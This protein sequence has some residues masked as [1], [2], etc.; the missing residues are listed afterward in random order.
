MDTTSL[1]VFRTVAQEG[2][3]SKAALSLN[4]VQ[5]NVTAKIKQL[6]KELKTQ[7]FY[8]HSRGVSLTPSGKTLLEYTD[9]IMFLIDEARKAVQDSHI[10]NGPL[11]IGSMETTAAVR[12]SPILATYHQNYPDVDLSLK[13]GPTEDLIQSVLRYD[14]DGAFVAGPVHHPEIV[15]KTFIE[16]ELVLISDSKLTTK[17][18]M[19]NINNRTILVFRSGCSYRAKLEEWLRSTGKFPIKIMEFGTL[20]AILACVMAG[21]G[22]SLLPKSVIENLDH[23][24]FHYYSIPEKYGKT[25]TVFIHRNDLY[26]TSAITRFLEMIETT[27]N[28]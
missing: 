23:N 22:I 3:I 4:F 14:L 26:K 6:E 19:E 2:S 21:M 15:Q 5:S 25:T 7:V 13:T 10:P 17:S 9:K 11:S 24:K 16:E 28:E 27:K 12:L 18:V 8:R 1:D 20:E